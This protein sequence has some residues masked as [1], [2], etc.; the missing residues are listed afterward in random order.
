MD[1]FILVAVAGLMFV[2]AYLIGVKGKIQLM[3]DYHY[4]RVKEEDKKAYTQT[5]GVGLSIIGII[6]LLYMIP[7]PTMIGTLILIVGFTLGLG[8]M[9]YA[10]YKYNK[11]IFS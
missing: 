8:V 6:L 4:Q 11:G 3:H 5:I 1:T 2:L 9:V 7:T 10:Q